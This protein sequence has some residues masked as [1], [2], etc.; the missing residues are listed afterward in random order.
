MLHRAEKCSVEFLRTVEGRHALASKIDFPNGANQLI[1][2][3]ILDEIAAR[4]WRARTPAQSCNRPNMAHSIMTVG[5]NLA[6]C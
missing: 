6:N 1:G 5:G 3:N 2:Q 4:T